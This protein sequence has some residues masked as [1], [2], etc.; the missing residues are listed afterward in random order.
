MRLHD[1]RKFQMENPKV[2]ERDMSFANNTLS[3][4]C[5]PIL[6]LK[7]LIDHAIRAQA[8]HTADVYL[9]VRPR[10][11]DRLQFIFYSH[12]C[13]GAL[14]NSTINEATPANSPVRVGKYHITMASSHSIQR[15]RQE[16]GRREK[17]R[18]LREFIF[19]PVV[20]DLK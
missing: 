11:G 12:R 18:S 4:N 20:K 13:P 16:S 6:K 10:N 9:E 15:R 17:P 19:G 5:L 2:L 14:F 3:R 1:F 8:F 7:L